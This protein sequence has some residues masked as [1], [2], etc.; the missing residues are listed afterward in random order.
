MLK[1]RGLILHLERASAR[2]GN[3]AK[4]IA[5][6]PI[7]ASVVSGVDSLEVGSSDRYV[8][9]LLRPPYPF[10]LRDA[11]VAT[12]LSHRR[13]WQRILDDNL[14]AGLVLEDDVK[15]VN[16]DFQQAFDLACSM[17]Q[18][19]DVIRFPV[20]DKETPCEV[21]TE[22]EA[23]LYR[24]RTIGLGM[25]AQLVTRD[26]ATHLLALTAQFDRPVDTYLQLGW[27]HGLRILSVWPSGIREISSCLGGS[28]IKQT[29]PIHQR[30]QHEILRPI[31]RL[32]HKRLSLINRYPN[33]NT[34]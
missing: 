27:E 5:Q 4:L 3:V 12:F 20:R 21:I 28:L 30:L 33:E 13:C 14:D 25:V 17:I 23:M 10:A 24:P 8:S 22:R 34:S 9:G 11:E 2:K 29:M 18:Q 16:P 26:A 31:Y 7:D 15:L 32:R 1:C 6:L 19:G